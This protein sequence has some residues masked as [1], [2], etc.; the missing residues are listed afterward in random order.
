MSETEVLQQELDHLEKEISPEV[1]TK[2]EPTISLVEQDGELYISSESDN[3]DT[4]GDLNERQSN[5]RSAESGDSNTNNE[6]EQSS[7][8]DKS[9]EDLIDMVVNAQKM[10]G[11]QS[12]EL[13]ELRKL[14]AKDEDLSESE[15]LERLTANDVQSSLSE[16]KVKLDGIDPYDYDAVNTQKEVIRS[17]ESDLINKRTQEHLES[18]FNSRD[19]ESFVSKMKERFVQDGIELADD[20][21]K[22]VNELAGNYTENGLLTEGSY[23][24]AMVDHFGYEKVAKHYQMS[25]ERKARSDIQN[26]S[27]KQ[28]E[29]V[30]VRGTGKN[31]KMI[32]IADLSR[33]ELR[34]TL[35]NLS[36]EELNKL[37][38]QISN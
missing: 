10:I 26:A 28:T 33:R 12:S 30:D 34:S 23:H 19:N 24:K 13:G 1:E 14:T 22:S 16:E 32:R 36:V 6:K 21:F 29:K 4:E 3:A 7:F 11:D 35:D 18:R 5:Q 37:N 9:K 17:L 2:E 27:A 31:A 25:G 8:Q 20:E 38:A 15:L